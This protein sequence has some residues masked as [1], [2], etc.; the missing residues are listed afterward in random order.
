LAP[1]QALQRLLF[2]TDLAARFV[3]ERVFV[4]ELAPERRSAP[5]QNSARYYARV[6]E[7]VLAA[8]CGIGETRPGH[9]RLVTVTWIAADGGV[10]DVLRIGRPDGPR[11]VS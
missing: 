8:L 5:D 3:T 2:G 9:Y 6:E 11:P 7:D 4:L 10:E 1:Q